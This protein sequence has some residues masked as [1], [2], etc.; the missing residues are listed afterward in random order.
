MIVLDVDEYC[1]CNC[2]DFEADVEPASRS[3]LMADFEEVK[4]SFTPTYVRCKHRNRC[5]AVKRYLERQ[6]KDK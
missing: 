1:Q 6:G 4:E 5:K 2:L 3:V